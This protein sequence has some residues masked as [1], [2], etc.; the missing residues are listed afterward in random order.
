MRLT[1]R[2]SRIERWLYNIGMD[3]Y[4]YICGQLGPVTKDHFFPRNLFPAPLPSSL[5]P[6][7]PACKDCHDASLS[8]DEELFRVFVTSGTDYDSPQGRRVW[9]EQVKP[10][11][12]GERPGLREYIRSLTGVEQL[13]TDGHQGS[14]LYPVIVAPKDAIQRVVSN[15]VRG[16]HH[17]EFGMPMPKGTEF[18]IRYA[19]SIYETRR[20][21]LEPFPTILSTA[22][23]TQLGD[24]VVTYYRTSALDAPAA[25]MT[26][27]NFYNSKSFLVLTLPPSPPSPAETP[28]A[29]R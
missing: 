3:K 23:R 20:R 15:M 13:A 19:E 26:W 14:R 2:G 25:S 6:R 21:L 12:N 9:D 7:Q 18:T 17:I 29:P 22:M 8:R 5:P 10:D 24:G 4:C 1:E 11:L 28:A 27:L 16:L